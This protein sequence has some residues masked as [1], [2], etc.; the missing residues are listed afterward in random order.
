MSISHA[1]SS[2]KI[3]AFNF[4][5]NQFVICLLLLNI[6]FQTPSLADIYNGSSREK[7][8]KEGVFKNGQCIEID[9]HLLYVE[10]FGLSVNTNTPNVIFLPGSGNN[11]H[12]WNKVVPQVAKFAHVVIYDRSGYGPSQQYSIPKTLT[13]PLVVNN[14]ILLLEKI[15]VPPPYIL[16][17]HSHGGLFAQY[18]SLMHPDMVRGVVLID[19]STAQMVLSWT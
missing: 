13:A 7:C 2:F 17:G 12:V 1:I 8:I 19:S 18:F 5:K 10:S 6:I 4:I 16:V 11:H 15:N 9:N 14:L 3:R